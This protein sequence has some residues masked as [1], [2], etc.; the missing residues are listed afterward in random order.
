MAEQLTQVGYVGYSG[1]GYT[2]CTEIITNS[3]NI[4]ANTSNITVNFKVMPTGNSAGYYQYANSSA[5]MVIT[6]NNGLSQSVDITGYKTVNTRNQYTVIGTWTGTVNHTNDGSLQ[7]TCAV[8]YGFASGTDAWLPKRTSTTF[9]TYL[10]QIPRASDITLTTSSLTISGTSGT[11]GWTATSKAD[12][13]HTL[14]WTLGSSSTTVS[15]LN[16]LNNTSQSGTIAYTSLLSALPT[17]STGT[18]TLTLITYSN[19]AKTTEIGRKTAT[20]SVSITIKPTTTLGNIAVASS[21]I[22]NYAIAGY[23][24]LS[25]SFSAT[26]PSGATGRTTY[27]FISTGSMAT[28]SST[29]AS[30]TATSNTLPSNVGTG[31]YTVTISAYTVDSRG[32]TGTTV[33]KSITCYQ[34]TQPVAN[35]TAIRTTQT[36]TTQD[37]GGSYLYVVFSGAVGSSIN[38]QNSVQSVSCTSTG[39]VSGSLTSGTHYS[40]GTDAS[41]KVTLTVTDKVG[42]TN[43]R[44]VQVPTAVFPIDMYDNGAGTVG[45]GLGGIAEAGWVTANLP[46]LHKQSHYTYYTGSMANTS[47]P[48]NVELATIQ[49]ID[50]YVNT[51]I[52]FEVSSRSVARHTRLAILF[53]NVNGTDPSVESFQKDFINDNQTFYLYKSATST[54]KLV[55]RSWSTWQHF[56]VMDFQKGG[57]AYGIQVT[58]GN[59]T[60]SAIP[61][62]AIEA[63]G[64]VYSYANSATSATNARNLNGV[65]DTN[66]SST[67]YYY[68][69]FSVGKTDGVEYSPRGSETLQ[70]GISSNWTELIIGQ[71]TVKRGW[72]LLYGNAS[73]Y[74][75]ELTPPDTLTANRRIYFPNM[76]GELLVRGNNYDTLWTGSL[77]GTNS[78]TISGGWSGGWSYYCIVGKCGSDSAF[79][80]IMVPKGAITTSDT[81]WQL[82]SGSTYASFRLKYSGNDLIVTKVQSGSL[83]AVYGMR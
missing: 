4:Q 44:V 2:Y 81:L 45:V 77:T 17:A 21:P 82:G 67:T 52:M 42:A 63:T 57:S 60:I 50:A 48:I 14:T 7:V 9:S 36:G 29:S 38:G 47:T 79:S 76:G 71:P 61:S 16:H 66:P 55:V 33:S 51:P 15:G 43:T 46:I 31:T 26:T 5:T 58:F 34:Y 54:W 8:T 23:S 83:T 3:Q 28:T 30:G 70:Y 62:G 65:I 56:T 64:M 75:V 73:Q 80:T 40:L 19:S 78:T 59:N 27:F 74:H 22:T 37:S 49:I 25:T 53:Q 72:L 32:N 11:I 6:S 69:I 41:A 39:G 13:Y 1:T 18:L 20:C 24:T 12:Y 68:P 35:L 10:E